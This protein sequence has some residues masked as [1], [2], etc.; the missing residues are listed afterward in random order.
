M[1]SPYS[2]LGNIFGQDKGNLLGQV[3][4]IYGGLLSTSNMYE[5]GRQAEEGGAMA[6]TSYR[7]AGD[8]AMELAKYN[9]KILS[10]NLAMQLGQ[11]GQSQLQTQSTQKAQMASQGFDMGSKSYLAIA[12]TTLNTY[13]QQAT[14]LKTASAV[15]QQSLL[16][17]GQ[18]A[19][20][21]AQN[22]ANNAE[23]QGKLAKYQQDAAA[24]RQGLKSLTNLA[25]LAFSF[26][27]LI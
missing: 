20:T 23:Y 6:A 24:D 7:Q 8:S 26:K 9:S 18:V 17:Q 19:Q 1:A 2:T 25:S 21:A 13:S 14:S 4:G 5:A 10:A 16:F 12:N 11:L 15:Q 27:K 3:G 22:Q